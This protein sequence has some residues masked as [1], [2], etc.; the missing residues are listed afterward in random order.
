[1]QQQKIVSETKS[2]D[3]EM[4]KEIAIHQEK[5]IKLEFYCLY[6]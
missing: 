3:M 5:K 1:M 2:H 6:I 4:R